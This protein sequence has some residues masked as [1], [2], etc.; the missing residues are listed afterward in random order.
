MRGSD[1]LSSIPIQGRTGCS[2]YVITEPE[3]RNFVC[4]VLEWLPRLTAP[5]L[6]NMLLDC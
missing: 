4:T 3:N 2:R 1:Q 6:V 5:A